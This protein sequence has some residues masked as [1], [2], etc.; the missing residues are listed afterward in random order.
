MDILV[1][2][3]DPLIDV[4]LKSKLCFFWVR[5]LPIFPSVLLDN[6]GYGRDSHLRAGRS[7]LLFKQR[8][9]RTSSL[10]LLLLGL[11]STKALILISLCVLKMKCWLSL[12]IQ[13]FQ[14]KVWLIIFIVRILS[15][16]VPW[17]FPHWSS[18]YADGSRGMMMIM[19]GQETHFRGICWYYGLFICRGENMA[20]SGATW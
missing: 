8:D 5:P 20:S 3:A 13:N 12:F 15:L 16:I 9:L 10:L 11:W 18:I 2:F 1:V 7:K 14:M 6:V 19:K 4:Y 17:S